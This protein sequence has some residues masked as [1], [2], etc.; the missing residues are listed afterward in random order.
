[1]EKTITLVP[2][3]K[4]SIETTKDGTVITMYEPEKE[5]V[6]KD[7]DIITIDCGHGSMIII[8]KNKL[9][10]EDTS[11]AY[12]NIGTLGRLAI[13]ESFGFY[14]SKGDEANFST[15]EEKQKLFDALK[16]EGKQWNAEKKCIEG[17]RWKPKTG[18]KFFFISSCFAVVA[19]TWENNNICEVMYKCYNCFKTFE[20][21]EK[22]LPYIIETF[23][24]W[25]KK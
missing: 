15:E 17:L 5:P 2:G 11:D 22:A 20:E 9:I 6:F 13:G 12:I 21:A 25:N 23:K 3:A 1:M 14:P 18:E 19:D 8:L 16:K 24:N 7:G 10:N 4:M